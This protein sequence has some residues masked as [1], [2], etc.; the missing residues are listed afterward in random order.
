LLNGVKDC[1]FFIKP[2]DD[3]CYTYIILKMKNDMSKESAFKENYP[4]WVV[5]F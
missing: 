1:S 2:Y 4:S 3:K 5:L